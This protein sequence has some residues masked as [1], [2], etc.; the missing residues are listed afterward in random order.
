MTASLHQTPASSA[1]LLAARG[2]EKS[3]GPVRALRGVDFQLAPGQIHVLMG[4]NGAGKSTLIK[5]LSGVHPPDAGTLELQGRA[6]AP[7]SPREAEAQ[8]ISTVF[9][10]VNLIPHMS[11]AE[12]ITLGREK[13]SRILRRIDRADSRRRAQAAIARL[14]VDINVRRE[15]ASCSI[16]QQQLVAIARAL[17]VSSKVLILDE[18][19]SSLDR[20]EVR[21]LFEIMRRLR[22]QGLGIIFITHFLD[23]VYEVADRIT[24][25]RDGKRVGEYD[26]AALPRFELVSLMIGREFKPAER[27]APPAAGQ[28][29]A[30]APFLRASGLG[31]PGTVRNISL[32]IAPGESLG[33]AGLLGSGRTETTRLLFGADRAEEGTLTI[34][35]RPA[36]ITSP[37]RAIR[38]RIALTTEDRKALGILPN[39]S[40]HENILIA[41]QAARGTL[42]PIRG[43]EAHDLVLGFIRSLGIKTPSAQTPIR[44]LSGGNQQKVLLARW[45][46]T[47]PR[48]LM[49]DEPTRGID[50]GAKAEIE[51]LIES[52]RQRGMALLLVGSDL[53]EIAR[54]CARVIVLR[55][56]R[57]VAELQGDQCH[58]AAI[59]AAIAA[60][61]DASGKT[62]SDG[63]GPPGVQRL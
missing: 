9:Q 47:D 36:P 55:D 63:T 48:L 31:R 46:A 45:L 43:R 44:N 11:V 49:L 60:E 14:G 17:D 41:L 4:E 29:S 22:G 12:N 8:G 28:R 57:Q 62:D 27:P 20:E 42:R 54:L 13:V 7:T 24:I 2:I 40:V 50:V 34:D 35:G 32:D 56:R 16:A 5:A 25:L 38:A 26:P 37:R 6:I 1:P 52:L 18:P 53:E 33:L 23:Q 30:H 3:F 58:P 10:E 39:L 15:L 61:H 59:M 21:H 51:R 19:T